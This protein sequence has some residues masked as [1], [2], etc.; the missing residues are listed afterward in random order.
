MR[1]GL[2]LIA[3]LVVTVT[4]MLLGVGLGVGW[5][6]HFFD[7]VPATATYHNATEWLANRGVTLGCATR[8]YCPNDFVTRAQM[9]LFMN[10][11]GVALTPELGGMGAQPG[12]LDI[13]ASPIICQGLDFMVP[14]SMRGTGI[15]YVTLQVTGPGSMLASID[16]VYSTNSGATWTS[17]DS[18]PNLM[19][20]TGVP[21]GAVTYFEGSLIG[22][23]NLD[24]GITYR[25]GMRITRVAGALDATD[26]FCKVAGVVVNRNPSSSP[27]SVPFSSP[28]VR[29]RR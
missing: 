15:G 25:V 23:L 12:P 21:S 5:A 9:A 8:L 17:L 19:G 11:L 16:L 26:S 24:S 6:N 27:L 3:L 28:R 22:S 7:D 1:K 13:D 4:G 10:R 14:F 29:Q 20:S 18:M 2:L